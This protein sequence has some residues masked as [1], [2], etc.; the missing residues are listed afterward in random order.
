MH[1]RQATVAASIIV[2]FLTS[3][4][5]LTM[6]PPQSVKAD[7]SSSFY[8][9]HEPIVIDGDSGFTSANGVTGGSG[10]ASNPYIIDGWNISSSGC[11]SSVPG[12]SI[13]NT[14]A[15]CVIRIVYFKICGSHGIIIRMCNVVIC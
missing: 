11:C 12:I 8:T 7:Y 13:N 14:S 4:A 9:Q 3:M 1:S 15:Y 5:T 2:M 6:A 10:T